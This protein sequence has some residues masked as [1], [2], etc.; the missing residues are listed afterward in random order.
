MARAALTKT[1]TQGAP[2]EQPRSDGTGS[3][4]GVEALEVGNFLKISNAPPSYNTPEDMQAYFG[5]FGGQFI[6]ETLVHAHD[7]LARQ[8]V[9]LTKDPDFQAEFEKL[10][11]DFIGRPTAMYHAERLSK[12][13]GG[14]Q[15]WI[16]REDLAHT[17]AH[18]INNAIGQVLLAKKLG[19]NRI[20]AETGAGQHGVATATACA[21]L[22]LECIVYM[23]ETDCERQAL[24]VFR[25]RTLGAKV[26]P[27]TSGSKT[28]KDAVNEA[29][30]D[31]VANVETTHYII[32]SAVGPHPFPTICRDFQAVIG[33]E[34]RHQI[35]AQTGLLPDV[36]VACCGGGS[37]A[38]GMFK[39]FEKDPDVKLVGV[40]AAGDGIDS[41]KH[42]ATL[43]GG[44]KGVLHGMK[45]FLIQ[46]DEGQI[47]E[48]HS[49]SAGLDYPGVGPEH[50][51]LKD[52]GRAS[53]VGVTD[54]QCLEGFSELSKTEGIIPAL[55]PSHAIYHTCE[56]AKTMRPDQIV[57][58][59]L[60]GRGDKDMHTVAQAMGIKI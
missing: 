18:K 31:W 25:M 48:T 46:S 34:S 44:T 20:I 26:V 52:S 39:A 42:A 6:P 23:G 10:G 21:L 15:I 54:K 56:L 4:L 43:A 45:T 50:S 11:R 53:F 30:R 13:L 3:A 49:I 19:K 36:V 22:G 24:N 58:V 41:G 47:V 2:R 60:S 16:K 33:R 29:M 8:Y 40:E 27:V 38:I 14:A 37:N 1:D 59:L 17:G 55:E 7:E 35:L 32:G 5:E 51:F 57:L 12:K 28:L 9:T